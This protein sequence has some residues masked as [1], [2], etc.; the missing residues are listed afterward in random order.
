MRKGEILIGID[1]DDVVADF[2]PTWLQVIYEMTG[3]KLVRENHPPMWDVRPLLPPEMAHIPS[4]AWSIPG[5]Y[6]RVQPIPGARQ[7][8]Q[9]L[10]RIPKSR[11]VFVTPC[12]GR[13]HMEAKLEWLMDWGFL[14]KE[15]EVARKDYYPAEDKSVIAV[16]YLLDDNV[17][18]VE[19][20]HGTGV[21]VWNW[22]NSNA[23]LKAGFRLPEGSGL[24]YAAQM[25]EED[26]NRRFSVGVWR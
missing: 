5:F 11:T 16:D 14:P 20:C 3:H 7:Y 2:I 26:I 24:K 1:V 19:T 10:R 4:R 21:L 6:D 8:V 9:A 12:P 17:K 23:V 13:G 15:Y 25:I 18:N 22:H